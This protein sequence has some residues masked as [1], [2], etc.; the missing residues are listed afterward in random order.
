MMQAAI[1]AVQTGF[2]SILFATDFSDAAA[3]AIPYVRDIAKRYDANVLT[4]HVRPTRAHSMMPHRIWTSDTQITE[5]EDEQ[6]REH[7]IRL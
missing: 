3:L 7:N 6:H 2:K 1:P 5:T 4:L